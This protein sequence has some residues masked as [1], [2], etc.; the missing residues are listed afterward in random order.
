MILIL[1]ILILG[2]S[3]G[4]TIAPD[5]TWAYFS[6]DGGDLIS[7]LVSGGVAHPAG[8]PLYL[9][10][11]RP[12]LEI[13]Y[14][15]PAFRTN[16]FSAFVTIC[17][18]IFLYYTI[19][20]LFAEMRWARFSA[21]ISALVFGLIPF[22]WGQALVTEVYALQGLL[23]VLCLFAWTSITL[24]NKVFIQGLVFGLALGSHLTSILMFPI[25]LWN[26]RE[27]RRVTLKEFY[28]RVAGVLT[29]LSLYLVL[30][31]RAAGNPAVNWGD[32]STLSGF[33]WL[34]SGRLYSHFLFDLSAAEIFDRLRSMPGL[35]LQQFTW[36][37]VL[38]A[39]Y[40]LFSLR[41]KGLR[42][43]SLWIVFSAMTFS[44]FYGSIDSQ[45]YLQPVWIIFSI[46]IASGVLD[47]ISVLNRLPG[48][49]YM[50]AGLMI[51][52]TAFWISGTF[53]QVDLSQDRT[54][55]VFIFQAN[56][57]IPKDAILLMDEDRVV[58]SMWYSQ[59]ALGERKD[60]V[61]ISRGLLGYDWYIRSLKKNY[62]GVL[63]PGIS[64]INV[65]ALKNANQD[66]P[67]CSLSVDK[68]LICEHGQ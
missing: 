2:I 18:V 5:L 41:S 59:L 7:A 62:P 52:G 67:V 14:G 16:L 36:V 63:F 13:P 42:A 32:V 35:I 45:V 9:V 23:L 38:A 4:F 27:D 6:A 10:L 68:G 3:Y 21:F 61:L 1:I 30:P 20:Q 39:L 56:I 19:L 34:V 28:L 44:V 65:E 46:W 22:T 66:R 15:S 43:A 51:A 50:L 25:L 54:A 57:S 26:Y 11:S 60:V 8:Y 64:S 31:V 47:L 12:F 49:R 33:L 40:G 29:G 58:F 17:A 48:T 37:G 24:K 55:G 53:Q